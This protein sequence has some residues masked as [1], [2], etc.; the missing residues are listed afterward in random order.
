MGIVLHSYTISR[1]DCLSVVWYHGRLDDVLISFLD[2][3]ECCLA[4]KGV[5]V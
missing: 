2:E 3:L 1:R 4:L 5:T